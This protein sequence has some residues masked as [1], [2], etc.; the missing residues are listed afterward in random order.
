M[1]CNFDGLIGYLYVALLSKNI[2]IY[3][4]LLGGGF[5]RILCGI[6]IYKLVC[7]T[8][9]RIIMDMHSKGSS[10]PRHV[11]Y[12]PERKIEIASRHFT[13]IYA[14]FQINRDKLDEIQKVNAMYEEQFDVLSGL[15][16]LEQFLAFKNRI[17]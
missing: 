14:T 13:N 15:L 12:T 4:F 5:G 6:N 3:C 1:N 9:S 10:S 16:T 11:E 2:D 8:P 17:R 7:I